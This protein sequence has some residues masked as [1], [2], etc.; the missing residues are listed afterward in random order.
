MIKLRFIGDDLADAYNDGRKETAKEIYALIDEKCD[1]EFDMLDGRLY[2]VGYQAALKDI[3]KCLKERFEE[4]I[5]T[6]QND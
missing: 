2:F 5:K 3:K 6:I 1:S 4:E